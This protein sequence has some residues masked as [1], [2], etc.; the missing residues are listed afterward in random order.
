MEL[1]W[2]VR[3]FGMNLF[4]YSDT[5]CELVLVKISL[6]FKAKSR[7]GPGRNIYEVRGRSRI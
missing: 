5:E 4:F 7:V 2:Q 3:V 1:I 6:G